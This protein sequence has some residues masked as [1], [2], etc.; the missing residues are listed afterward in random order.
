MLATAQLELSNVVWQA[1]G[2]SSNPADDEIEVSWEV[3]NMGDSPISLRARRTILTSVQPYNA[4]NGPHD[5]TQ[6]GARDRFCWGEICFDYGTAMSPNNQSL[7]VTIAPG[8]SDDRFKGLYEHRGVAG[9]SHFRYC[10]FEASNPSVEICHEALFC[11]D[12]AECAVSVREVREPQ[13]SVIAP[14]PVQ[15]R[16]AFNYDFGRHT[17]E[18]SVVVYNMV[19][20]I[21]RQIPLN[22]QQGTVFLNADDFESGIYFYALLSNG[23]PVATRKFIVAR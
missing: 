12:A 18:R 11:V 20:A 7:L 15:S 14:N 10:F 3:V 1:E 23:S 2:S 16:S 13:L 22:G 9:V 21:V 19:G 5:P 8:E 4:T 6:A 17:G